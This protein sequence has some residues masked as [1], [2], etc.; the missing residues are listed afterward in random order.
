MSGRFAGAVGSVP[1][2]PPPERVTTETDVLSSLTETAA[3]PASSRGREPREQ[4]TPVGQPGKK[5]RQRPGHKPGR[6]A[7]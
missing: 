6:D 5:M 2:A 3:A 7:L 1:S 4:L